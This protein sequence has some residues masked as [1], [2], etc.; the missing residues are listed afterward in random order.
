MQTSLLLHTM[1]V[2]HGVLTGL[3]P[4]SMHTGVPVAQEFIPVLQ[5]FAG[6]QVPAAQAAH[7]PALQTLLVPPELQ[8]VP[9]AR[10]VPVSTHT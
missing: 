6:M 9:F 4:V 7:V 1:F 10:L 3:F 5:G 8:S 2:P